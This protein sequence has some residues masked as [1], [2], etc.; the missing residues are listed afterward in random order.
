MEFHIYSYQFVIRLSESRHNFSIIFS[1]F[2]FRTILNRFPHFS[3]IQPVT[4]HQSS[5]RSKSNKPPSGGDHYYSFTIFFCTATALQIDMVPFF[6]FCHPFYQLGKK[7]TKI[8]CKLHVLITSV[9][10]FIHF[11]FL[12]T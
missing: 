9:L 4:S 1:L 10:N 2:I 8:E 7:R 3:C 6:F 5:D 11:Y 12:Y